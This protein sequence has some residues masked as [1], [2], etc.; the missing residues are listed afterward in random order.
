VAALARGVGGA[1]VTVAH[2][3]GGSS[4]L[5]FRVRSEKG[6]WV[7][8][9][10]PLLHVLAT[11]NDMK[12]EYTVQTALRDTDVPVAGTVAF[13]DDESV[14]GAPFYLMQ[15]L[16]GIVFNTADDVAHLDETQSLAASYELMDALARLHSVD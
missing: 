12:R 13:C 15:M 2:V 7:L 5:T 9:R 14:I 11:A 1:E 8:R 6:D 4:N 10:P 3:A 16:D